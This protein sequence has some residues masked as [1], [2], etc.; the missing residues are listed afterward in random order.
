[1]FLLDILDKYIYQYFNY[2]KDFMAG[3]IQ[4]RIICDCNIIV[5][6]RKFT[7]KSRE[8]EGRD[9]NKIYVHVDRAMRE[10]MERNIL[11]KRMEVNLSENMTIILMSE[12]FES[13]SCFIGKEDFNYHLNVAIMKY[14]ERH[15]MPEALAVSNAK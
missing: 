10:Y 1:M 14:I 9:G 3:K 13:F 6:L 12:T 8:R 11:N 5:K 15:N 2:L 4:K 7:N